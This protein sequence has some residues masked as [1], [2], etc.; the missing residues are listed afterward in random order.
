MKAAV[1]VLVL[2]FGAA[3]CSWELAVGL[4]NHLLIG[5]Q[6]FDF[7]C[8]HNAPLQLLPSFL[9]FLVVFSGIARLV[10][11]SGRGK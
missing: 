10:W 9:L 1:I 4:C 2:V 6:A 8:G 11:R 5:Y 3:I 7:V